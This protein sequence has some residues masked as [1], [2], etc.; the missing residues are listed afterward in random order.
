MWFPKKTIKKEVV[1]MVL[2]TLSGIIIF[3]ILFT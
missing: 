2:M 1:V 3:D